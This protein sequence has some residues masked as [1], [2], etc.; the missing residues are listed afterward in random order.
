MHDL[1]NLNSTETRK[2]NEIEV[3]FLKGAYV[4]FW[5]DVN[6]KF[7]EEREKKEKELDDEKLA[8]WTAAQIVA[9]WNLSFDG[10]EKIPITYEDIS[11]FSPK[12][13]IWILDK[14][15]ETIS[16]FSWREEKKESPSS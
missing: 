15:T 1:V 3:P 13:R 6:G 4:S 2:Q 16:P 7:I 9:D 14:A 10:R 12:L 11:R 8:Y 5:S